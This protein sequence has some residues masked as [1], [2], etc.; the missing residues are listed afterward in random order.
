MKKKTILKR[1]T[2]ICQSPA[3]KAPET[4]PQKKSKA[5]LPDI[6]SRSPRQ[7]HRHLPVEA[8]EKKKHNQ[9]KKTYRANV[10]CR[11]DMNSEEVKASAATVAEEEEE[12]R[13]N[14][15]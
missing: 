12:A 15:I 9:L 3:N 14:F 5:Q 6:I 7:R 4:N 13:K 2:T 1:I 11:A 10:I 8:R